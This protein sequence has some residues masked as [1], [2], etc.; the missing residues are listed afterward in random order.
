M[1]CPELEGVCFIKTNCEKNNGMRDVRCT[2]RE[3]FK[4]KRA[5]P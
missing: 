2:L 1:S 4:L 5:C 3:S